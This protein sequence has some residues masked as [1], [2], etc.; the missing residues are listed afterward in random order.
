M[1]QRNEEPI[2]LET[3]NKRNNEVNEFKNQ[4]I[5]ATNESKNAEPERKRKQINVKNK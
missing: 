4:K 1:N 3:M 5:K 2:E